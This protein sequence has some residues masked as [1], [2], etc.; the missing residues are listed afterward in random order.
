MTDALEDAIRR[1]ER[2]R[3][4]LEDALVIEAFDG[5]EANLLAAWRASPQRDAEGR[6]RLWAM[7]AAM[8]AFK[9]A[10][11]VY[12]NDGAIAAQEVLLRNANKVPG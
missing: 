8:D 9:A 5:I 12:M 2:A 7:V 6:E 4:I 11:T 3:A 1:G 10:F